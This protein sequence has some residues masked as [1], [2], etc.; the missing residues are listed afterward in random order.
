LLLE[1][2]G[3]RIVEAAS[4]GETVALFR[5]QRPSVCL[6]DLGMPGGGLAAIEQIYACDPQA[7][8]I[9]LTGSTDEQSVFDAV[10]AGAIGYLVK[11][12]DES[13]VLAAVEGAIRGEPILPRRL[14][15]LLI[16]LPSANGGSRIVLA[17][18]AVVSLTPRETQ[19]LECLKQG[20]RTREIAERLTISPI[21]VRRH[22]S[23]LLRKLDAPSREAAVA[24][25]NR[26][27]SQ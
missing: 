21:T 8:L 3:Y 2:A 16:G 25:L 4:A 19:V 23:L 15:M 7:K 12:I 13:G 10:R 22:I 24:A 17:S 26:S 5:R 1:P 9:V 14:L 6:V 18:G 20:L 27:S 11:G